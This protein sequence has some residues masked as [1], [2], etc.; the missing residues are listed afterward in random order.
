ML[1]LQR[2]AGNAAVRG[3]IGR[4]VVQREVSEAQA[5]RIA[6]QLHEAMAGWGTDEEAIYGASRDARRRISTRSGRRTPGCRSTGLEADLRDELTDSEMARAQQLMAA[7]PAAAAGTGED[8]WAARKDRARDV[9]AQL[10]DAMAGWG[11]AESQL[12]NA[13]TGRS[14]Y[15]IVEIAG[16][17]AD[18]HRSRSRGRPARRVRAATTSTRR[19]A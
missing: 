13:L 17:Y 10:R 18:P 9:A 8:R 12:L 1:G 2:S 5:D 15:E 16:E 14:R 19:S 4:S 6:G 3:L 11:T 7:A